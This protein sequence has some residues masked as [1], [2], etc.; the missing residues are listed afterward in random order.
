MSVNQNELF[1]NIPPLLIKG[2]EEFNSQS[3]F[4]CHETLETLWGTQNGAEKLLS[5]AIIQFAVAYYHWRR[6][7]FQG[8]ESL[9]KRGLSKIEQAKIDQTASSAYPI[10]IQ[11]LVDQIVSDMPIVI[12]GKTLTKFPVIRFL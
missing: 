10:D 4:D 8:A 5:Q 6:L 3:Y 1:P 11:D 2:I 9:F 7:N 12:A